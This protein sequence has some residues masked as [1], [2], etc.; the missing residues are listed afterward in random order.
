VSKEQHGISIK[1]PDDVLRGVYANQMMVS[2]TREEFV[3]DFINLFPPGGVVNA[4]VI[5][6]PGHLKRMI[7]ALR[8]NLSRYEARF[9]QVAEAEAPKPGEMTN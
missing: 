7:R 4:R 6:S 3:L 5:V 2:H 1:M 9:G 8:E